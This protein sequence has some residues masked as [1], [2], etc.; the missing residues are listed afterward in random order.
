MAILGL[1][2]FLAHDPR[3]AYQ[4]INLLAKEKICRFWCRLYSPSQFC[5]PEGKGVGKGFCQQG[6]AWC[7]RF[8]LSAGSSHEHVV[9]ALAK[10]TPKSFF[11]RIWYL[12]LKN[13]NNNNK[14]II[15]I[16]KSECHLTVLPLFYHLELIISSKGGSTKA[17]SIFHTLESFYMPKTWIKS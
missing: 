9:R 2:P 11:E 17:F 3:Q 4:W 14:H 10:V 1:K 8:L 5:C 7:E 16:G 15:I 6:L 12:K 13:N